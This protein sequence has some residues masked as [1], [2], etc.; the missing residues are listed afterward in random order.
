MKKY[1]PEAL[2]FEKTESAG[3]KPHIRIDERPKSIWQTVLYALQVTV[4]DFTP[5]IWV[6]MFVSISG[7]PDTVLPIMISTSFLAMGGGTLIQTIWGNRLPIVQGPSTS[8]LTAMG[9]VTASFGFSAMWGAVIVGGILEFFLGISRLVGAIRKFIPPVVTGS[10]VAAIGFVATKIAVTWIF[11]NPN[12]LNLSLALLGF[13]VALVLKFK[14]K[15]V[16]SHGFIL[17]ATVIV[18]VVLA[19]AVG[20]FDWERVHAAP[21]FSIP[22]LFPFKDMADYG[23]KPLTIGLAAVIGGFVGY[24]GSI[25]ESVGDY[26]ATAAVIDEDYKVKHINRG[27]AAEG[28]GCVAA[29][30]LGGLP[31]TSYTQNAGVIAATGIASRFVTQIA[32]VFFLLYGLSPKLAVLLSAIPRSVLG[33]VFLITANL[34]MFSG[35]DMILS[36][37]RSLKNNMI[38][39]IT[40]GTS[41]M[42]PFYAETGG[43]AF[44]ATLGPFMRMFMG[45][46]IFIA[47]FVGIFMN[48]LLTYVLKVGNNNKKKEK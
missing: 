10:V 40:L 13:L 48:I 30:V 14:G 41:V 15:G 39:G 17:F 28:A 33:G 31:L 42:V 18:G 23:P 38:A 8:V 1:D 37:T 22:K 11:T 47:V 27:I 19:S 9:T 43:A 12:A 7:L 3:I 44:V 25:L 26:A 46:N 21:W 20:A 36:E 2:V 29:G 34:I 4:V 24:I 45:S 6:A 32:A 5:F 35:I 16:L